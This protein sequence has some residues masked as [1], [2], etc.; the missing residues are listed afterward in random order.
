[1]LDQSKLDILP[2]LKLSDLEVTPEFKR[3]IQSYLPNLIG[4][5]LLGK[6]YQQGRQWQKGS[7]VLKVYSCSGIIGSKSDE[8][9]QNIQIYKYPNGGLISPPSINDGLI[10]LVMK[11]ITSAI[12]IFSSADKF[13]YSS[14]T[15]NTYMISDLAYE[16]DWPN[17]GI[18]FLPF[19]F[20]IFYGLEV[21]NSA[22]GFMHHDM[23]QKNILISS[24]IPKKRTFLKYRNGYI[25]I[26]LIASI[27]D[28]GDSEIW[29]QGTK[30]SGYNTFRRDS[31][32][33]SYT[34]IEK[35]ITSIISHYN[36]NMENLKISSGNYKIIMKLF[37][38]IKQIADKPDPSQ[39][40]LDLVVDQLP[41][42]LGIRYSLPPNSKIMDYQEI[43]NLILEPETWK[44]WLAL[45]RKR[46]TESFDFSP[47]IEIRFTIDQRKIPLGRD[48][49]TRTKSVDEN[50]C[51]MTQYIHEAIIDLNL[52]EVE[53]ICCSVNPLEV[54]S[55]KFG[56]VVNGSYFQFQ[57][58]Q[59]VGPY[60]IGNFG[61]NT[62]IPAEFRKDFGVLYLKDG[63]IGM[64]KYANIGK[65]ED[66]DAFL[67]CGPLMIL[68]GGVIF[69][70]RKK[71]ETFGIKK[72]KPEGRWVQLQL[73]GTQASESDISDFDVSESGSDISG[74]SD[75]MESNGHGMNDNWKSNGNKKL[76]GKP[77]VYKFVCSPN[78]DEEFGLLEDD[79]VPPA[80]TVDQ[81]GD[82]EYI[83]TANPYK[84]ALI[85]NCDMINPGELFHAN[86]LNPR[87]AIAIT[88]DNQLIIIVVEGRDNRG[89]GMSIE[90]L[91]NYL[92]SN[93]NV[94]HA[95][96]LD[97]GL[98]SGIWYRSSKDPDTVYMSKPVD[99]EGVIGNCI[100]IR[101]Y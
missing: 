85:K 22:T 88:E 41:K 28:Y 35:L 15:L 27:I 19:L 78:V 8:F 89:S 31:Y 59:P 58:R 24:Q 80:F 87:S 18:D 71:F 36:M 91:T 76:K 37:D 39:L 62:N 66:A 53:F 97:G 1:M 14:S 34:D 20:Q 82:C 21:L 100:L 81:D 47:E 17:L 63:K 101:E 7:K 73:Q 55:D 74:S 30:L 61:I 11:H 95:L 64:D 13:G 25:P 3:E 68:N 23:H 54:L 72:E 56:V 90:Q 69:N 70:S 42:E 12:G 38:I 93:Y 50:G 9:C 43:W 51:Q 5:G 60:Q 75:S 40:F 96:N 33:G 67:V 16:V 99:T 10:A 83:P 98:T 77:K 46:I 94:K 48:I 4:E 79:L 26:N 49:V 45:E 92:M 32:G 44:P 52:K 57:A 86:N 6:V 84:G 65:Y 2:F 29:Y